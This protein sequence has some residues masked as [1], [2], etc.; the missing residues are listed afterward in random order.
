MSS[1]HTS[2]A[3]AC[4]LTCRSL[5]GSG[6][7]GVPCAPGPVSVARQQHAPV[8]TGT[9]SADS[10]GDETQWVV[11]SDLHVRESSLG[12][13]LQEMSGWRCPVLMLVGNHDQVSMNEA[14]ESKR[15][16]L[17]RAADWAVD[18]DGGGGPAAAAAPALRAGVSVEQ[19]LQ[20]ENKAPRL[21]AAEGLTTYPLSSRGLRVVVGENRDEPGADS[22]GAGKTSLV[23]AP[24][25]ALTGDVLARTESGGGGRVPVDAMRNDGCGVCRV[26]LRGRLN[27]LPF[28]VERE[29]KRGKTSS[30]TF[31]WGGQDH[32]CQDVSGTADR[33]RT[34]FSVELLRAAAFFGQNDITGLLEA[35]D[36]AFK[37]KLGLV[38]DLEEWQERASQSLGRLRALE[39]SLAE[40]VAAVAA[41]T[42]TTAATAATAMG[43][44]A[45]TVNTAALLSRPQ[46]ISAR[47]YAANVQRLEAGCAEAR[48]EYESR[49]QVLRAETAALA[50]VKAEAA[51][52]DAELSGLL[53]RRSEL[54]RSVERELAGLNDEVAAAEAA[55]SAAEAHVRALA[56]A[57]R[58]L[59]RGGI[60]SLVMEEGL[61]QLQAHT[62]AYLSELCEGFVLELSATKEAGGGAGGGGRRAGAGK[63]AREKEEISKVVKVLQQLDNT[64]CE[65]VARVLRDLPQASVLVV[66]QS[67]SSVTRNFEAMD[68]VV[69][70]GGAAAVRLAL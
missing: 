4:A 33:I 24:L 12:V 56:D 59:G 37:Q 69:R 54:E 10:D 22:N 23:A 34:A 28:V 40:Y 1:L 39:A 14:G 26:A 70:Q 27:G 64:G 44:A 66:G 43:G 20:P 38:I 19:V 25:W 49:A 32:T 17:L 31:M 21:Q 3:L 15:L 16:L 13:C 30:L 68:V 2:P 5:A 35:N 18:G 9:A 36:A 47:L 67:N 65:L 61:A 45:V 57:D 53:R 29:V 48:Q 42:A 52:A 51:E 7:T 8:A 62:S 60:P 58:A 41:L 63:E 50:A 55:L 6:T 46:P 11:F